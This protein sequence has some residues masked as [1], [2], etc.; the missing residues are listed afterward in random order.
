MSPSVKYSDCRCNELSSVQSPRLRNSLL[1][2]PQNVGK[3]SEVSLA[4][5]ETTLFFA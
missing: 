3:A 4:I 2:I 1:R 5:H